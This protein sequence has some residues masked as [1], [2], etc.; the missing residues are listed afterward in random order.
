MEKIFSLIIRARKWH[1]HGKQLHLINIKS[2]G[3]WWLGKVC[4]IYL[5]NIKSFGLWWLDKIHE[6]YEL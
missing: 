3:L 6:I 1:N 4:E 5:I 2:F